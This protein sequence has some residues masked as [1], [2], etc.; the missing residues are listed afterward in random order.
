[1]SPQVQIPAPPTSKVREDS[2]SSTTATYMATIGRF[3]LTDFVLSPFGILVV[4]ITHT[5][6]DN[7]ANELPTNVDLY[8]VTDSLG[9]VKN[10]WLQKRWCINVIDWS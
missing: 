6:Y 7:S 3:H 10:Q 4:V 1:M 2:G 8:Q 9:Q 5:C